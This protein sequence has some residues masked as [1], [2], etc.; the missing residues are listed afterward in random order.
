MA[1]SP[2]IISRVVRF[3]NE[4]IGVT[5]ENMNYEVFAALGIVG[6]V[7]E[8]KTVDSSRPVSCGIPL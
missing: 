7:A 2:D 5:S 4:E 8:L 6:E 1:L 3:L